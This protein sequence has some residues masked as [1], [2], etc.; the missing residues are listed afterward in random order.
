MS[1]RSNNEWYVATNGVN[2]NNGG[3]TSPFKT[4]QYAI[5]QAE[6]VIVGGVRTIQTIF[7]APGNYVENLTMNT[8]YIRLCG[9]APGCS[10]I[11]PPIAAGGSQGCDT[12][13]MAL[14]YNLP[15]L[16]IN[17]TTT[18]I[19][20]PDSAAARKV[21][22][23]GLSLQNTATNVNTPVVQTA[24]TLSKPF[25][26]VCQNCTFLAPGRVLYF[27]PPSAGNGSAYWFSQCTVQQSVA[28][29]AFTNAAVEVSNGSLALQLTDVT[30]NQ[31][32][33]ALLIGGTS[34]LSQCRLC[35]FY[36]ATAESAALPI[37]RI[38]STFA[39][40][41]PISTCVFAYTSNPSLPRPATS[42]AI[43]FAGSTPQS[44]VFLNNMFL[45]LGTTAEGF[46][47]RADTPATAHLVYAAS[48]F[49]VLGQ[50]RLTNASLQNMTSILN[51]AF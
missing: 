32:V 30:I 31:N 46:A 47:I 33:P 4:V 28:S 49:S 43:E 3:P 20:G 41:T 23:E 50:A 15:V 44:G 10:R 21:V 7:I 5:T 14:N 18:F 12:V 45:L 17:L 38:A 26:L 13:L 25:T 48:N 29:T 39:Y 6:A 24:S 34:Y 22:L 51:E 9:M 27:A 37:L 8:G 40:A 36:S 11:D 2:T 35:N 42:C 19:S 1:H 16:N